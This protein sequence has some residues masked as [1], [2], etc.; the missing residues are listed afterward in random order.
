MRQVF[1]RVPL[2]IPGV[3]PDG[4]P[5]YGFGAMLFVAFV[6]CLW[7]AGKRALKVGV[8]K[9]LAQDLA[10]WVIVGGVIG[11]RATFLLVEEKVDS[12]AEFFKTFLLIW[13]GGLVWY[14][15]LI[16]GVPTFCAVYY[17]YVR[18]QGVE[19][20]KLA[21][22]YAPCIALGLCFGRIGCLLNGCCYGDVACSE[23][24]CFG[25][26]YPFSASPHEYTRFGYQTAA[27]F[28]WGDDLLNQAVV[29][30]VEPDSAAAKAGLKPGDLI[31]E[32]NEQKVDRPDD[33]ESLLF[34]E[35]W[36]RGRNDLTLLVERSGEQRPKTIGPFEPR[37]IPLFPT[38]IHESIS[39][40][41]LFL[42]MLAFEPFKPR[43]GSLMAMFLL[44]Y[45]I[46][47]FFDEMLRNDT[48][49][50]K[51]G[52]TFSQNISVIV[53]ACAVALCVWMWRQPAL[54]HQA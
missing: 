13:K 52:M 34:G 23:W 28:T 39:M 44:F 33:L 14:G 26:T 25:V 4:I 24:E 32:V 6:I 11:A 21:D 48:P 29:G 45:P 31:L 46:H 42:L 5:V 22:I 19:F 36:Q 53:F 8:P 50:V 10:I 7:L 37:S 35:K 47:R 18:K 43:E 41:L 2:S 27:G 38:Q 49:T 3:F 1:F 51:Y 17:F 9:E 20:W 54:K 12:L 16:A 40:F 15:S 30:A